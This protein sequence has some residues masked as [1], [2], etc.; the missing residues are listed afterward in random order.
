MLGQDQPAGVAM[1]QRNAEAFLERADLAA[2]R[3]LAEV[4]RFPRMGEAACLG[5]GMKDPQLVPIH[6]ISPGNDFLTSIAG[7]LVGRAHDRGFLLGR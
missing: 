6:P 7:L 2:D 3:G 5:D 1:E 4:Q